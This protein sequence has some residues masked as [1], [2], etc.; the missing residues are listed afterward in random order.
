M[1]CPKCHLVN[2]PSSD[3]CDC[4]YS[5]EKGVHIG[6]P[7][8]RSQPTFASGPG[9]GRYHVLERISVGYYIAAWVVS[10]GLVA[11]GIIL[12][13][14]GNEPQKTAAIPMALVFFL[15]APGAWL[16][17]TLMAAGISL[18]VDI[19]YDIRSIAARTKP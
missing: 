12:L 14:Q 1:E 19:A 3:V 16:T 4:G 2:P 10:I 18:F 9:Q 11:V 13:T 5:F 7:T 15:C 17:C 6:R 8:V